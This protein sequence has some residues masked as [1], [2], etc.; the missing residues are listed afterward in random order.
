MRKPTLALLAL[1]LVTANA[2]GQG[3][4]QHLIFIVKENR[5]F[6]TLFNCFPGT[7]SC[8]TS[9]PC[10]GTTAG[11]S[12]GSLNVIAGNPN[13]PQADCGHLHANFI[14][15]YD[16]GLM[17]KF[18]QNCL[19]STDWAV[20]FDSTT[21]PHYWQ[22][23]STYGLGAIRASATAP[24]FPSH[25]ILFAGTTSETRDNPSQLIDGKSPH[26][27]TGGVWNLDTFHY[28]TCGVGSTKNQNGLCTTDS[29]CGGKQGSCWKD[30]ASGKCCQ[31]G[32]A[33]DF[34]VA[35]TSCSKNTDCA[36]N[37]FCTNGNVYGKTGGSTN[38]KYY[39]IDLS[40]SAGARGDNTGVGMFPGTCAN[41]RTTTCVRV[42][43][44]AR[45]P[46]ECSV[47]ATNDDPACTQLSDTCDVGTGSTPSLLLGSRGSVGVNV[48]TVADLLDSAGVRWGYYIPSSQYL[49]NPVSFYSHL[50]YGADRKNVYP[51]TQ[52]ATDAANCTSSTN[53]NLATVVWVQASGPDNEHPPSLMSAGEAWSTAQVSAVM[54]NSYLW[55]VSQV[56][57]VWDDFGGFYDHVAPT[58]DKQ[59]WRNGFRVPVLSIGRYAKNGFINTPFVFESMLACVENMFLRGTRLPGGLFDGTAYDLCTGCVAGPGCT[60]HN[61]NGMV[62][63]T[64]SNSPLP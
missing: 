21:L 53:C 49:R 54:N 41:H 16:S 20:T 26:G 29:D 35:G 22:F 15:D 28:G 44:V 1:C 39:S 58:L 2:W 19:G 64:L 10:K 23:A 7:G 60:G 48:T 17:N 12:K 47:S 34:T 40:G 5:S 11:C 43:P 9:Y 14:S 30:R 37:Q 42:C 59:D 13:Q 51:D 61:G 18:N 24:T 62:D 46:D 56:F 55:S 57:I 50:W 38:S 25:M 45:L 4:I 33:C 3:V 52:F 32:M 27:V 36:S 63:L 31:Q 6:D 8:L